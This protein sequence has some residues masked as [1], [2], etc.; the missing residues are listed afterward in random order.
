M[1]LDA[2]GRPALIAEAE[3]NTSDGS[4]RRLLRNPLTDASLFVIFAFVFVAIFRN[5]LIPFPPDRVVLSLSNAPP[6]KTEYILGGDQ[7]G[8]DILSRLIYATRPALISAVVVA[9]VG[10]IIGV[11][12]G[13]IAG[14][15]GAVVDFFSIALFTIIMA[16]PTIIVL[17]AVYTIFGASLV[18]AMALLGFLSAPGMFWLVRNMTRSIRNELYVDAA[19]VAGV[20]N[21]RIISVH[22]LAAIRAPLILMLSSLAAGG[23][24]AQAGLDFL[25]LGDTNDPSWGGMLTDAFSNLYVAPLGLLWPAVALGLTTGAFFL[26]SIGIRD[27]TEKTNTTSKIARTTRRTRIAE[28]KR[29]DRLLK[30]DAAANDAATS[31]ALALSPAVAAPQA[32]LPLLSISNLEIVYTSGRTEHAVVHDVSLTVDAGEIVG[33][34]GESGSGKTQTLFATLGLLPDGAHV[35]HGSILFEGRDLLGATDRGLRALRGRQ[36]AYVPQEPSAN[37]DPTFR[38]GSQLVEG[39]RSS[40]HI[41]RPAARALALETLER[42]GIVDPARTFRSFPHE[43]S[44]GMAQRVLIAG[45]VATQPRL[46]VADEPTTSLDVTI[47]AE[48]LDLLRGLQRET[49]MG[50]LIVTHNFGVVADLCDRVVVMYSGRTIEEGTVRAVLADPQQDYTRSLLAAVLDNAPARADIDRKVRTEVANA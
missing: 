44:G 39:I 41:S 9:A 12:A 28:A 42:V 47:Q 23:I 10:G 18:I 11:S 36:I 3:P 33:V 15:Y 46:L 20:P 49:R 2:A 48:V 6:F 24:A 25:G 37:L 38:V 14:F 27:V 43:I 29:Q 5:Q 30:R 32:S 8:R 16:I 45:A 21:W 19:R 13:L 17:I 35:A 4:L 34:V 31:D 22:V 40:L 1:T 7:V 26:V 50:V